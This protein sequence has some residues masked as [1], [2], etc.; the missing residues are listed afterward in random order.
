MK[1][2]LLMGAALAASLVLTACGGDTEGTA[3]TASTSSSSTSSATTSSSSSSAAE[4]SESMDSSSMETMESSSDDTSSTVEPVTLDEQSIAWFTTFCGSTAK[5]QEASTAMGSMSPDPAAPPA[6]T[7]TML[8][9]SVKDFGTTFK[10]AASDL[11]AAPAPTI[12]GGD[13][14]ATTAADAYNKVGDSLIAAGDKFAQTPVTD[15]ASLQAAA[16]T[17]STEI[18]GSVTAIQDAIAPL[19][20]VLT[21]ELGAAV[22]QIPGCE[23]ISGS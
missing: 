5:I 13:Q 14:L 15:A 12:D 3:T 6:E 10:T 19:D 7:Q 18:Q 11:A 23:G 8:A 9:T 17:L 21:D 2:N 4:T 1:K 20:T 22:E 16:T